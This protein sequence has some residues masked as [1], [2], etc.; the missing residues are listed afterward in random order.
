[1]VERENK[2]VNISHNAIEAEHLH[3]MS[4]CLYSAMIQLAA[5][6]LG[7]EETGK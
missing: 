6:W 1:M 2:A 5:V 4:W 7:G 3:V